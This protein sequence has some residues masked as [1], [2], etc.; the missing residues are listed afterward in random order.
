[1]LYQYS[2]ETAFGQVGAS[3]RRT[4]VATAHVIYETHHGKHVSDGEGSNA[5]QVIDKMVLNGRHIDSDVRSVVLNLAEEFKQQSKKT[6]D[7]RL[8]SADE[9]II[10]YLHDD[11]IS[12]EPIHYKKFAGSKSHKFRYGANNDSQME[13][14]NPMKFRSHFCA[15]NDCHFPVYKPARC[16]Y[17]DIFSG[18]LKSH[19]AS[20]IAIHAPAVTRTRALDV[21]AESVKANTFVAV[22]VAEDEQDEEGRFWLAHTLSDAYQLDAPTTVAGEEFEEGYWVVDINWLKRTQRS[23]SDDISGTIYEELN[24]NRLLNVAA[25]MRIEEVELNKPTQQQHRG[26]GRRAQNT[27]RFSVDDKELNRIEDSAF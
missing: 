1:M 6:G 5:K 11:L 20:P 10:G 16:R 24:D 7:T 21:F 18:N 9:Y 4:G 22:R 12:G 19:H 25:I 23:R 3:K 15:C 14:L 2:G 17:R 13:A 8:W 26:G 27:V